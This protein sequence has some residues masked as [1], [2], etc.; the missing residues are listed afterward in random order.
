MTAGEQLQFDV[1]KALATTTTTTSDAEHCY[2]VG[3][4]TFN[5]PRTIA[6]PPNLL[7]PGTVSECSQQTN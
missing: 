4:K 1:E 6:S 2:T 3:V 5:P 7:P